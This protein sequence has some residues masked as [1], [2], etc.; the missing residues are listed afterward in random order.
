MPE[1][2]KLL[3]ENIGDKLFNISLDNNFLDSTPKAKID[4]QDYIKQKVLFSKGNDQRNE[5]ATYGMEI[6]FSKGVN[7]QNI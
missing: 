7:I 6:I 3:K 1:K 2:L 5:K 4:K